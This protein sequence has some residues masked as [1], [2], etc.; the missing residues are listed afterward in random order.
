MMELLVAFE[1]TRSFAYRF[2]RYTLLPEITKRIS[3][4]G[5]E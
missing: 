5:D 4:L 1:P 3:M 2:T